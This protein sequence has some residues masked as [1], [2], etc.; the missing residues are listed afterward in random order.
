MFK[1]FQRIPAT[2]CNYLPMDFSQCLSD[3]FLPPSPKLFMYDIEEVE[4][5]KTAK[6]NKL[7]LEKSIA[8]S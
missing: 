5:S 2:F 8:Q 6:N 4:V 1:S 3:L 7:T